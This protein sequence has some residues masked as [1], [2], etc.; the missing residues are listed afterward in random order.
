MATLQLTQLWINLW[1][2]GAAI[3]GQTWISPEEDFARPGQRRLYAGGRTRAITQ[4]GDL[5]TFKFRLAL[6]DRAT[7]DT[8][9]TWAGQTV[10]VRDHRGRRF[11]GTYFAVAVTAR[12]G[13]LLWNAEITLEELTVA[14][15]A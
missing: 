2:T 15:G 11:V 8:L 9:R 6:V 13:S 7:V 12:R 4:A 3:T 1:A 14:E 10:Q 5:G